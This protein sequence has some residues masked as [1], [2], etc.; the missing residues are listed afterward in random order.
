M[1]NTFP[2]M[3][4]LFENFIRVTVIARIKFSQ[5]TLEKTINF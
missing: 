4:K 3:Q 1:K 2:K 5:K